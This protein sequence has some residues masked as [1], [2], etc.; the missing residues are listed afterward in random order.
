MAVTDPLTGV[1]NRALLHDTL[2]NAI[3]QCRRTDLPMTLLV[4]DIDHFKEVNDMHGHDAGDN[5]LQ[6]IGAYLIQ[7]MRATDRVFRMGGEEF[8]MLLYG[9]DLEGG[10]HLAE[11][12]RG[13]IMALDL[14]EDHV[15][16]VS[17]G[18]ATLQSDD[19]RDSWIR[20]GDENL[21]RAKS[22]GRNKVMA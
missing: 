10:L 4:L 15:I 1:L 13:E 19:S 7:S 3:Y 14:L 2:E 17:V 18:V 21:Y 16:T 6:G 11:K 20:R 12:I 8:L 22:S 9:T 5:V